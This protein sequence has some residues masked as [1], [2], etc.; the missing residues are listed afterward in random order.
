MFLGDY[1]IFELVKCIFLKGTCNIV[2]L[3]PPLFEIN[4]TLFQNQKSKIKISAVGYKPTGT[5]EHYFGLSSAF[6]IS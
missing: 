4:D 3:I 5:N 6:K 2:S 1:F